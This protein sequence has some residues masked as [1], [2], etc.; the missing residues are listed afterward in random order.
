MPPA[1][2]EKAKTKHM[3]LRRFGRQFDKWAD[4]LAAITTILA[5]IIAAYQIL[6]GN[7]QFDESGP[8]YS[9]FMM[10]NIDTQT[11]F[12]AE[13]ASLQPAIAFVLSNTGRTEDTIVAME[14]KTRENETMRF[15]IPEIDEHGQ[16]SDVSQVS[17]DDGV[18]HLAPGESK[19]IVLTTMREKINPNRKKQYGRFEFTDNLTVYGASGIA[20]KA[21]YIKKVPKEV[22]KHY[23][24]EGLKQAI[25][26]C[27]ELAGWKTKEKP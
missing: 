9:W 2:E 5:F 13:G 26:K 25:I 8:R 12:D 15:C 20:R 21:Q 19:L 27:G 7:W 16:L 14:R 11:I 22:K 23:D 3:D 4:R 18:I 6:I 1:E 24:T 17:I 10:D